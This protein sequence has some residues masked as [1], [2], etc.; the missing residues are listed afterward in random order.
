L[1]IFA[2]LTAFGIC[3]DTSIAEVLFPF[4][5]AADPTLDDY[6]L[7]ALLLALVQYPIYGIILGGAWSKNRAGKS[8]VMACAFV[9]ILAHGI[10]VGVAKHRV[11]AMWEWRFSHPQQ[12]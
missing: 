7:V 2:F 6:V 11:N 10:A 8:W 5:L 9:L 12:Q 1:L 3:S 4:S